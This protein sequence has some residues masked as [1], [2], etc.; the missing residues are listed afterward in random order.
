MKSIIGKGVI[1]DDSHYVQSL[2][3]TILLENNFQIVGTAQ[4]GKEAF[5][6]VAE[7]R[8]DVVFLDISLP[9]LS[10]GEIVRG[11]L[12][13][14]RNMRIVI[15]GSIAVQRPV[16]RLI[17]QGASDYIPKPVVRSQVEYLLKKI[18][19]EDRFQRMSRLEIVVYLH[20]I[21]YAE[22]IKTASMEMTKE[23]TSAVTKPLKRL[24]KQYPD[25]Y[26]IDINTKRIFVHIDESETHLIKKVYR[27]VNNLYRS[28]LRNLEKFM[29]HE[30]LIS[31][32]QEAFQSFG[33][34]AGHIYSELEY[35]FPTWKQY[36]PSFVSS[37]IT[38]RGKVIEYIPMANF[39][40]K[41]EPI[42]S[43]DTSRLNVYRIAMNFDP[44]F[45][46]KFPRKIKRDFEIFGI[47]SI[48]DDIVGPK[49][50][51]IYPP[52]T[53]TLV[54]EQLKDIPKLLDLTGARELEPFIHASESFA[55]VNLVFSTER[56]DMRGSY[57][58]Q[59]LS[60]C[61]MPLD[62]NVLGKLSQLKGILRAIV[63]QI[64]ESVRSMSA[65]EINNLGKYKSEPSEIISELVDEV[66]RF[67]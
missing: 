22:I 53:S 45:A 2:L 51:I 42:Y 15:M 18:E 6:K 27:Q 56:E 36:S 50:A 34:I 23:V 11:L 32:L 29:D 21:Y 13:I 20:G 54:Q 8:P 59:M 39:T 16:L 38:E 35:N 63:A 62:I 67:V 40:W 48:F 3:E 60:I 49:T 44:R 57:F 5:K 64:S 28:I 61:V 30:T 7:T 24:M 9:D 19:L 65:A 12:S 31:F 55:S 14:N 58:D 66:R 47:Y 46:P 1:V 43:N 41:S 4:S 37:T 17:N 25:R 52:P 33:Y 26:T 10:T